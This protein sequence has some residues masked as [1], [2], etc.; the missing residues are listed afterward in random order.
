MGWESPFLVLVAWLRPNM[1]TNY[2]DC[3][4]WHNYRYG[5]L[6]FAYF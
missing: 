2:Q 4:I 5:S 6:P 3:A 1:T